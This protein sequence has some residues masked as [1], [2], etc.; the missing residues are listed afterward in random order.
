ME[1]MGAA[2]YAAYDNG[3]GPTWEDLSQEER[4]RWI[5]LAGFVRFQYAPAEPALL[6]VEYIAEG[7]AWLHLEGGGRSRMTQEQIDSIRADVHVQDVQGIPGGLLVA[8]TTGQVTHI[9][10]DAPAMARVR[11]HARQLEERTT[12]GASPPRGG[13]E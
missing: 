11:E 8:L 7:G 2:L 13:T 4:N 6:G 10:D 3:T 5:G 1:E 9:P 12:P